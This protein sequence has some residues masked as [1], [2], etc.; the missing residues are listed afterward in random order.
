VPALLMGQRIGPISIPLR[1]QSPF[2]AHA[3]CRKFPLEAVL[4]VGRKLC[5]QTWKD[6]LA[7]EVHTP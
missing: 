1:V 4:G 3:S 5:F 6:F 7:G 2:S